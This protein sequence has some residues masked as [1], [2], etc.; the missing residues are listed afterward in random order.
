M[1]LAH[2]ECEIGDPASHPGSRSYSLGSNLGQVVYTHY[3][4]HTL[5]LGHKKEFSAPKWLWWLSA[6]VKL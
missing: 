1:W 6:L 3:P 4:K 5:K 2:L